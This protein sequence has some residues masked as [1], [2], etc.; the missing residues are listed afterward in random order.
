MVLYVFELKTTLRVSGQQSLNQVLG[1]GGHKLRQRIVASDDFFV[2]ECG[3]WVL[4]RQISTD[5]GKQHN[6]TR[7]NISIQTQ[8][9]LARNHLGGGIAR[10][11]AGSFEQ[12]F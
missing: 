2:E 3:V 7:P 1:R 12:L 4:K 8:V 10:R 5:H 9:L 11:P 6:S